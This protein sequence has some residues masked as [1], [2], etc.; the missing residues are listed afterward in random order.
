M[1]HTQNLNSV[2]KMS[3]PQPT[4]PGPL[5]LSVLSLSLHILLKFRQIWLVGSSLYLLYIMGMELF[6]GVPQVDTTSA[7]PF[8]ILGAGLTNTL[9]SIPM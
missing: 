7:L 9:S 1:K 2:E 5:P 4:R 3:M 6:A 8:C